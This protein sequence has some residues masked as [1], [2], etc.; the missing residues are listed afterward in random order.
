MRKY[1]FWVA[2][3]VAALTPRVFFF[4]THPDSVFQVKEARDFYPLNL[5]SFLLKDKAGQLTIDR[6]QQM[7]ASF[8]PITQEM[9]NFNQD[10]DVRVYWFRCTMQNLTGKNLRELF[11]LHPGLDSVAFFIFF[12][13]GTSFRTKTHAGQLTRTKPFF[14]SRQIVVPLELQP[15]ITKIY[16]RIVNQTVRSRELNSII[17]SLADERT[18]INYLLEYKLYQGTV[19]GM[20]FLILVLHIFIYLFIRDATYLVFLVNVFF[21]L[22]YLI[23]R[24][25]YHLEFDFLSPLFWVIPESHDVF[26]VL[27]SITAVWFAQTFLSTKREDPL[28]HRIMNTLMIALGI[29]AGFQIAFR[30]IGLMNLL[31]IYFG[32]F[33]AIVMI[34]SSIRSYRRGNKLALYVFFGFMLLAFV[35]L[36]YLIPVP[37]YLHY[38]SDESDLQYLGEAIRSIIFAVGIAHRFYLLKKEVAW[39]EIEKKEVALAQEQQL[40]DEKER[41]SRDLHDNIGAELAILSMELWQVSKEHPDHPGINAALVTSGSI[42]NQLR[43]TIW[44]IEKNQVTLEDLES[45]LR[46]M[47]WKHR[48]ANTTIQF[49]LATTIPDSQFSL[50]PVQ[51]INLFRIVQEAVQNAVTHSACANIKVTIHL[52]SPDGEL[53]AEIVDDGK[54]FPTT[55]G[56]NGDT[57]YGLRNM[58]KRAL[59]VQ[60]Q[61]KIVS[62]ELRGTSVALSFPLKQTAA[63]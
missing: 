31:T 51:S 14:I 25:N 45:R 4:F 40:R 9:Y 27:I 59:E 63:D 21:T 32:F 26:G 55:N 49:D 10:K 29:V 48:Q 17:A 47:L 37:N 36:T 30:W 38:R 41:I 6:V 13:D 60:G 20:L 8:L 50:T 54:G 34:I 62:D 22:I 57:H 42:Y 53:H 2:F 1:I 43:D 16:A 5:A 23:L 39:H 28:M 35:P 18:F 3:F 46:V 58:K 61:I 15:G 19:I 24:K 12:P 33:S 56:V 52:D 7:N 44:A 11:C